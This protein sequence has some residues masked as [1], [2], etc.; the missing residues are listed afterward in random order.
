MKTRILYISAALLTLALAGACTKIT[1]TLDREQ[2]SVIGYNV[3]TSGEGQAPTK[4]ASA[5]PISE[6]FISSAYAIASSEN[7]DDNS[8]SPKPFFDTEAEEVKWQ[9]TYWSTEKQYYWSADKKLTFFSYAPSSLKKDKGVSIT[10][11]GVSA[12]GWDALGE[13][14]DIA[15][16]VADIAKDKTKNENYAGFNGVPTH[17]Q[18]KLCK[19]TFRF[20]ASDLVDAGTEVYL[21]EAT[22]SGF[23][24]KGDYAKGGTGAE[25]WSNLSGQQTKY[26]LFKN[27]AGEKLSSTF[28]VKEMIM[29]PQSTSGISL[30]ISY[31]TK[32]GELV[33]PK[34]PVILSMPDDFRSGKWGKGEHITYTMKIGA[35]RIPILFNGSAEIWKPEDGGTIEIK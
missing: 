14:K 4:A 21:T 16:L 12:S 6:S 5:F 7:W 29:I 26:V 35:G 9:G 2:G 11:E 15:L 32:T 28:I 3:V 25:S 24:T 34:E 30:T 22:M 18:N 19:L 13:H 27:Y 23:Y 31:K 8:S 20:A 1:P 17:V 33:T 10:R